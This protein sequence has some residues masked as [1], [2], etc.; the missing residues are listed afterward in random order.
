MREQARREQ[1]VAAEREE[2]R[3]ARV[4]RAAERLF[5]AGEQYR[6]PLA[7]RHECVVRGRRVAECARERLPDC[8]AIDLAVRVERPAR[9]APQ[10]IG[11]H[12]VGQAVAQ[13]VGQRRLRD[14]LA[15]PARVEAG[16]RRRAP[17]A[18][19]ERKAA[20]VGG[21]RER[22]VGERPRRRR[23]ARD[24]RDE[25]TQRRIAQ[26]VGEQQAAVPREQRGRDP[27]RVARIV[28]Q[29]RGRETDHAIECAEMTCGQQAVLHRLKRGQR[30]RETCLRVVQQ[31]RRHVEQR[32]VEARIVEHAEP[33]IERLARARIEHR[34]AQRTRVRRGLRVQRDGELAQRTN[35]VR[36]A[37]RERERRHARVQRHALRGGL[38]IGGERAQRGRQ[39]VEIG[40]LPGEPVERVVDRDRCGVLC[41]PVRERRR[42]QARVAVEQPGGDGVRDGRFRRHRVDHVD[43]REQRWRG[44]RRR[45]VGRH[46]CRDDAR[47]LAVDDARTCAVDQRMRGERRFDL[48]EFDPVP[49]HLHLSILAA[50]EFER[51][52][53]PVA[54]AVA[55]AIPAARRVLHE[56]LRGQLGIVPVAA[57]ETVATDQQFARH[58]IGHI[59]SVAID[60]AIRLPRQRPAVRNRT[61]VRR[62]VAHRLHVRP[63]AGLGRAAE[64]VERTGVAAALAQARRQVERDPVAG[65]QRRAHAAARVARRRHG[66][67]H[68]QQRGRRVP[69]RH[70]VL[71]DQFDPACR[72][73]RFVLRR[74]HEL[75][76]GA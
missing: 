19:I 76:T 60:D 37:R 27:E 70:A 5:P 25:F 11:T 2:R 69:Q 65:Q 16:E 44:V 47:G 68:F 38:R 50:E 29:V 6:V 18:R 36:Q 14:R 32:D 41:A 49:A 22:V 42:R 35:A 1:A 24:A 55:G 46:E 66:Q 3:V 53:R 33:R 74:Q 9:H 59:A 52:V 13:P 10:R 31:A 62:H 57:R 73:A 23:I 63:D 7:G 8:P 67:R 48:A 40:C 39:S 45:A 75:R 54:A 26:H 61:P 28:A 15:D 51:P 71:R 72:I 34:D 21:R 20:R 58:V 43:C 12:R 4:R 30:S 56:T 64:R 17:A